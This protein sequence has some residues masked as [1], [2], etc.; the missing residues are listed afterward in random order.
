M[1]ILFIEAGAGC[2]ELRTS[3][4]KDPAESS[5]S[6][7]A[8]SRGK[9]VP[10][11][12]RQV[13]DHARQILKQGQGQGEVTRLVERRIGLEGETRL[14]AEFVNETVADSFFHQLDQLSLGVD[15][16]NIK[17]GMCPP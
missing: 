11:E 13:L 3:E 4:A 5:V 7:Y 17:R 14:C 8:L 16:M 2:A 10:D 12:A 1:P 15:L 9:G 6:V